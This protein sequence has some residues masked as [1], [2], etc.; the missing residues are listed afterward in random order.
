[1]KVVL[2]ALV[3]AGAI[4]TVSDAEACAELSAIG[5][6]TAPVPSR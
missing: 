3:I 6:V 1:V 2:L 5:V 4:P